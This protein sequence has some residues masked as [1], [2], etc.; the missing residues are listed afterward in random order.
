MDILSIGAWKAEITA[1]CTLIDTFDNPEYFTVSK[2]YNTRGNQQ[3][4]G[5]RPLFPNQPRKH[6]HIKV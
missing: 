6:F 3:M 2:Y 1:K 4:T 5:K